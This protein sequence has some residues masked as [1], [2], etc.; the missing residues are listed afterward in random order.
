MPPLKGIVHAAGVIITQLVSDFKKED[1]YKTTAPK[2]NGGWNLHQLSQNYNLDLFVL[3]SSAS[4]LLGQ[5]GLG[6]YVS[7][8]AFLDSLAYYRQVNGLPAIA[9]NWGTMSDAGM[10]TM[11]DDLEENAN[12]GG[13]A[14][15]RMTEAMSVF[16]MIYHQNYA[17]MGIM[18]LDINQVFKFFAVLANSNF[19]NELKTTETKDAISTSKLI[20]KLSNTPKNDRIEIL[21][22]FIK[23]HVANVIKSPVDRLTTN[24]SFKE[25]GIDSLMAVQLRNAIDRDLGTKLTVTA[26]WKHPTISDYAEFLLGKISDTIQTS[27]ATTEEANEERTDSTETIKPEENTKDETNLEDMSLDDLTKVLDNEMKDII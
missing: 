16:E 20:D 9:I 5:T 18:K 4:T 19:L 10:L 11:I 23:E 21:E 7:A 12:Q 25:L 1:F 22:D 8:N 24:A 13:Y 14:S 17:R 27:S 6:I 3:F 15:M 2:I 26:F